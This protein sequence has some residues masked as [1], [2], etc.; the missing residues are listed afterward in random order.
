MNTVSPAVISPALRSPPKY[1]DAAMIAITANAVGGSQCRSRSPL[2]GRTLASAVR[3]RPTYRAARPPVE[4][5]TPCCAMTC[6]PLSTA[7]PGTAPETITWRDG[8]C[9]ADSTAALKAC[10]VSK[11]NA[12]SRGGAVRRYLTFSA[13][14]DVLMARYLS[15]FLSGVLTGCGFVVSGVRQGAG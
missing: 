4:G 10:S 1:N 3:T 7:P 15:Y 12:A 14:P 11:G 6:L 9:C 13:Q 5:R 2:M 8:L